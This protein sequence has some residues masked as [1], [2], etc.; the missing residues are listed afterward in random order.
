MSKFV[1]FD[2]TAAQPAPVIG[3]YDTDTHEYLKLPDASELIEVTDTEWASRMDAPMSVL[4]GKLIPTPPPS[5]AEQL[6]MEATIARADRDARIATVQWRYERYARELRLKQKPTD[7]IAVLDAYVQA[8][9]DITG[10]SGFPANIN[11]PV[12]P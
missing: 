1:H 6:A 8:L 11:W 10:Q 5:I 4:K 3:F 9:A 12:A 7:D 2:S